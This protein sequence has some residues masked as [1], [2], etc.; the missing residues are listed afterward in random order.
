MPTIALAI[1]AASKKYAATSE[2]TCS[3]YLI[4]SKCSYA[5]ADALTYIRVARKKSFF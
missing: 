2:R 5:P 3:A 1:T 4:K